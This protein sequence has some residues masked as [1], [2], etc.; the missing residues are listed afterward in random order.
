[1]ERVFPMVPLAK[2]QGVCIGI[3]S[4]D[5][6]VNFGL[7]GDY[8]GM[9][10][11]EDLARDLEDSIDELLEAAGGRPG[12]FRR[13]LPRERVDSAERNGGGEREESPAG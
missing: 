3:M 8:D 1:M 2:N 4:Y 11:L 7:I 5:G 12:L 13:F 9:T 10:D 6:Q